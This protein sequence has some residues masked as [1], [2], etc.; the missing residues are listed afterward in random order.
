MQKILL[1]FYMFFVAIYMCV[2]QTDSVTTY[3]LRLSDALDI[4]SQ[5]SLD[6]LVAK[7]Q[8]RV[9]YWR[10]RDYKADLL[11]SLTFR[12]TIPSLNRQLSTYQKEDGTY[13]FI[14][15]RNLTESALLSVTQNI[16]YTGGKISVESQLQRLDQLDG[17]KTTS[18]LTVPVSITLEQPL[19][20]SR[21]LWWAKKIEPERYKEA[22]QQYIAD[23]EAVS[24]RTIQYYFDLLLSMVN[25]DIA[26]QTLKNATQLYDIAI[27]KKR[28]GLI[29]DNDVQ[30]LKLGKLNASAAVVSARQDYDQKMCD[31]RNYLGFNDQVV[32][33]AVIPEE[34]PV[35]P[36]SLD[37]VRSLA[38]ANNPISHNARRRQLE[39]Q[40]LIAEARANRGFKANIY[41]SIGFTGSASKF[42]PAYQN[43][44]NRQIISLGLSIPILDWGK[45]KGRI[46]LAKS[47]ADVEYN[48]IQQEVLDFEQNI[49]LAV[50]QYHDQQGLVSVYREADTVAQRRYKSIFETFVMGHISVLDINAAQTEKDQAR[51]NYINQLYLSWLCFYNLRQITLF[52]FETRTNIEYSSLLQ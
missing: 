35:I 37:E 7:D 4:A 12:G 34:A 21:P 42:A 15:S 43:L 26:E 22:K 19:I 10:F 9:Y 27:G 33:E 16:P 23:M 29:S 50:Q 46:Q 52:D 8:M 39:A 51:R 3:K 45:G 44:Q 1:L 31:L 17:S 38:K 11:P 30:Q 24:I 49:V 25:Y 13:A 36:I 32:V 48:R 28:L 5:Q 41:A 47:Q 40:Q 18:W 20:T 14:P 6:A 2:A